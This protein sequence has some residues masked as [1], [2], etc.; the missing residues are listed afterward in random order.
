MKLIYNSI[1]SKEFN[2]FHFDSKIQPHLGLSIPKNYLLSIRIESIEN[3][4]D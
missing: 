1:I 3:N 4:S 2:G